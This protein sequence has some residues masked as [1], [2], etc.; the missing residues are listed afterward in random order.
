MVG[1]L[2]L[3]AIKERIA[4]QQFTPG[5]RLVLGTMARRSVPV[6]EAIRQLEA[7]GLG[8]DGTSGTRVD[9]RRHPV[10][11]QQSDLLDRWVRRAPWA[12]RR[13][14]AEQAQRARSIN[15]L[16]SRHSTISILARSRDSTRSSTPSCSR[17]PPTRACGTSSRRNGRVS[18][19]CGRAFHPRPRPGVG[20]RA[21]RDPPTLIRAVC[22]TRRD[23]AGRAQT[24]LPDF[25]TPPPRSTRA[26]PS[27]LSD[28]PNRRNT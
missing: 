7:E 28:Q 10:P 2:R 25:S 17:R 27:R 16:W 12:A 5:Y 18:S 26:P 11:L 22:A 14:T 20:A 1:L 24:P 4:N 21:R 8:D 13:L 6:R 9:G 19:A 3:A 23:Q 15:R